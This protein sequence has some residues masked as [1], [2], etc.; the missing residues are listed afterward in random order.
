MS[1]FHLFQSNGIKSQT[2]AV[3]F[4]DLMFK[5]AVKYFS[6]RKCVVTDPYCGAWA[7]SF[8]R[9]ELVIVWYSIPS[10]DRLLKF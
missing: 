4:C 9:R 6:T 2:R 10:L 7:T 1:D 5:T 8:S 3:W